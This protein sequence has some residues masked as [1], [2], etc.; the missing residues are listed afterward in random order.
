MKLIVGLG[1]PGK[2]YEGNRHSVGFMVVDSIL[3][4]KPI[5]PGLFAGYK[6]QQIIDAVM[7]SHET[8]CRVIIE[9]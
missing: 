1:N 6:V 7:Q 8:G 4:D 2:K 5:R 9:S 3:D